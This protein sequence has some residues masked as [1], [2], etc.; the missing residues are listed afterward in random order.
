VSRR[1]APEAWRRVEALFQGAV[2]LPEAERPAFLDAECAGAPELRQRVAALLAADSGAGDFLEQPAAERLGVLLGD[3]AP[4]TP[5]TDN[6]AGR[7]IGPY[8]IVRELGRGG[9]GTVYLAERTDGQFEQRVALKVIRHGPRGEDLHRRFLRERQILAHL[10]HPHIARLLDGGLAEAGL[11]YFVMEYVEGEAITDYCARRR[12][13]PETMLRLFENVCGAV[14]YAHRN[15]IVHRDLKP[16]NIL[17]TTGGEVKLLDFGIAKL[18]GE[19]A[20]EGLTGTV[21]PLT[22]AYAAPEQ[23][24]GEPVT[25]AADVYALGVVLYELLA[26]RRPF[27]SAG[28]SPGGL[29][30][31]LVAGQPERPSSVAQLAQAG[32]EALDPRAVQRAR[33]RLRGDLDN[34]ALTALRK[35]PDRRYSSAEALAED[36]RRH[37]AGLPVRARPDTLR[38]RAGKFA[39]RHRL[40]VAAAGLAVAVLLATAGAALWQARRATAETHKA[41][42]VTH[43][44]VGLFEVSDPAKSR[45][46][47]ITA[48]EILDQGAVRIRGELASQPEVNA[49]LLQTLASVYTALGLYDRAKPLAQ[50]VLELRRRTLSPRDPRVAD[51]LDGL[52]RVLLARSDFAHTEPL[53]LKA[54]ELRRSAFGARNAKVAESLASLADLRHEQ[55]KFDEAMQLRQEA[56][57]TTRAAAGEASPETAR[58]LAEL[59]RGFEGQGDYRAAEGAL[60]QALAIDRAQLGETH[61]RVA[62]ALHELGIVLSILG[63]YAEARDCLEKALAL[64]ERVLGADHPDVGET[65]MQLAS[66]EDDMGHAAESEAP[67]QRALVIF[68]HAYGED[69]PEVAN[70]INERAIQDLS[71]NRYEAAVDKF[72]DVLRRHEHTYGAA[73]PVTLVVKGNLGLALTYAGRFEEAEPIMRAMID[74]RSKALGSQNIDLANDYKNLG[75]LLVYEGRAAE[76]LAVHRDALERYRKAYGE[77]NDAYAYTLAGL[78]EAE[79]LGGDLKHAETHVRQALATLTKTYPGGH[80]RIQGRQLILATFLLQQH[81]PAEAEPILRRSLAYCEKTDGEGDWR[82]AWSRLLLGQA[83]SQLERKAEAEPLLRKAQAALAAHPNRIKLLSP[84]AKSALHSLG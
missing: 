3:G 48:R 57:A 62:S 64:R 35:D 44:L 9:M 54:L 36:L 23:L 8:R 69:S 2:A 45:G 84:Y 63:K 14:H 20:D 13:A 79:A 55:G 60:R 12:L 5:S 33:R 30:A 21:L 39:R 16:S 17:V 78:A 11:P 58:R 40:G 74:S 56:L 70:A 75:A 72:R 34:I 29:A 50:E 76:A 42:A 38:Y 65:L 4:A 49:E 61:P 18:L 27:A 53:L 71:L 81:R 7:Q 82:T 47:A 67:S 43:F 80:P 1:L 73:H 83:L 19:G 41:E 6:W 46:A 66:V 22:P 68:R 51:S 37:L 32:T 25:T 52:G 26:G 10:Q 28:E 24:R 59:A 15:L 31:A 77:S